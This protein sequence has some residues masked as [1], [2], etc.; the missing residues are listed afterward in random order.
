MAGDVIAIAHFLELRTITPYYLQ[1]FFTNQ[2]YS[3]ESRSWQFCGFQPSGIS[4]SNTG[5]AVE[6]T[7]LFPN[8]PLI[9]QAAFANDGLRNVVAILKTVWLDAALLPDP[10]KILTEILVCQGCSFTDTTIEVRLSSVQD[11]VGKEIP[12]RRLSANQES[13]GLLPISAQLRLV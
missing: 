2:L 3:Y 12:A 5:D 8:L 13:V 11:A 1:N 10:T 4:Q 7:L 9:L 6:K